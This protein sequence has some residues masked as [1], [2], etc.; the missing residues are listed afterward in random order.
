MCIFAK[1]S[2]QIPYIYIYIY[3]YIYMHIFLII[4]ER[5]CRKQKDTLQSK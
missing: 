4:I 5:A 1:F 3:I 2:D